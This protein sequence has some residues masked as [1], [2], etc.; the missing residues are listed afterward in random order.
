MILNLKFQMLNLILLL[1]CH[2]VIFKNYKRS[3]IFE[4]LEIKSV[5][6]ELI[7]LCK[8]AFADAEIRRSEYSGTMEFKQKPQK[9]FK[10]N[11]H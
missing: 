10:V 6:N 4:K 11:F 1:I 3:S 9:L 8:G 7:F 5:N 2:L